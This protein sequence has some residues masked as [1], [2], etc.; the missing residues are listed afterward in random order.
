MSKRIIT[1]SREFGSGGRAIGK[2]VAE[3]LGVA[4]YDRELIH[5]V[6]KESGFAYDF[7]EENDEDAPTS[8]LYNLSVGDLYAQAVFSPDTLPPADQV[9]I[10]Q[11]NL[12]RDLAKKEPCVIIGRSADY[13][14]RER[15]DCLNVF[16]HADTEAKIHRAVEEYG[17]PEKGIEKVL[18]KKDK[19]R[20]TQY[21]R[22]SDQVWGLAH[23]Y[24]LTL[25]SSLFG[26][27][28]CRDIIVELSQK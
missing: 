21:R 17:L 23:N 22:N 10:V 19:A 20:A 27:E 6:A 2:M 16:I 15:T 28:A 26:L 7:V 14:L 4:F 5:L 18:A 1:I 12:I 11:S 13:I 24:H 9:Q 25:D 3:H 8:L